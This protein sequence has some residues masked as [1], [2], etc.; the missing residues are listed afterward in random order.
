[1][2]SRWAFCADDS[3]GRPDEATGSIP[4]WLGSFTKLCLMMAIP[5][6]PKAELE[7]AP[8]APT[9]ALFD[10]IRMFLSVGTNCPSSTPS[11]PPECAESMSAPPF[12]KTLDILCGF[13]LS[14]AIKF[15]GN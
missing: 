11:E 2:D 3:D 15:L 14:E 10:S 9:V 1:M 8:K 7:R 6:E 4:D 5:R 13:D 12:A